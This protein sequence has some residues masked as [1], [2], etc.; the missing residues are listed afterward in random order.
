MKVVIAD[1][2]RLSW[3]VLINFLY[4]LVPELKVTEDRWSHF[5]L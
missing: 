2:V 3:P 4:L 1:L 5:Q